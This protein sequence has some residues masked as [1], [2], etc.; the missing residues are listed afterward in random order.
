MSEGLRGRPR[1]RKM[2]ALILVLR[3]AMCLRSCETPPALGITFRKALATWPG[4]DGVMCQGKR[5]VS[6]DISVLNLYTTL[7]PQPPG[8]RIPPV[9]CFKGLGP[10]R[11]SHADSTARSIE[12]H[13]WQGEHQGAVFLGVSG[14][15]NVPQ[16]VLRY[17]NRT[18][19]SISLTGREPPW[20]IILIPNGG[21]GVLLG[22]GHPRRCRRAAGEGRAEFKLHVKQTEWLSERLQADVWTS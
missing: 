2:E 9:A 13:C 16:E 18:H 20:V 10:H 21:G 7:V 3:N 6:V 8:N 19:T 11:K 12:S 22:P 15:E 14:E 4:S 5:L 1:Q 17:S